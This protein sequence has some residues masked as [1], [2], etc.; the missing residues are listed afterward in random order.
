M[1]VP[2]FPHCLRL[3]SGDPTPAPRGIFRSSVVAFTIFF[4]LVLIYLGGLEKMAILTPHDDLYFL[5]RSESYDVNRS[6]LAFIKEYPYS[7]LILV[8]RTLTV[9]LILFELFLYAL[10]LVFL[11]RQLALLT[12]SFGLAWA[13]VLPLAF[14]TYLHPLLERVTY[15]NLQLIL[16]PMVLAGTFYL[17]RTRGALLSL[18]T[19][20]GLVSVQMATRPEGFIFLLPP[21]LAILWLTW[22]EQGGE[23]LVRALSYMGKKIGVLIPAVAILPLAFILF[24]GLFH[25]FWAQTIM[26]SGPTG[27]SL[28]LLMQVDPG[29]E[30]GGR[31]APFPMAAMEKA[32]AQSP[33]LARARPYFEQNT[34]F[35]GWSGNPSVYFLTEDGSISGGHFQWAWLDASN[36]V[37][38]SRPRD[39]LAYQ[40]EVAAELEAAFAAGD[41][42]KRRVLTTALGPNFSLF[43]GYYWSSVWYL[44]RHLTHWEAPISPRP[45]YAHPL[46]HLER[47][48]DRLALR[49]SALLR[50]R[51]WFKEGWMLGPDSE[52]PLE[53]SLTASAR[54]QGHRVET[55][56]RPDVVRMAGREESNLRAGFR[57]EAGPVEGEMEG[58]LVVRFAEESRKIPIAELRLARVNR[59][60][61]IDGVLVR[62][63]Q[64]RGGAPSLIAHR[65]FQG[66]IAWSGFMHYFFRTLLI[67]TPF[68]LGFLLWWAG[69]EESSR[70]VTLVGLHLMVYVLVIAGLFGGLLAA[71]E[72]FM[73][74]GDEP[75]YLAPAAFCLWLAATFTMARLGQILWLF[76]RCSPGV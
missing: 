11:W 1:L 22:E 42:P 43:S 19:V 28:R 4:L 34:A 74:P 26:K 14:F 24:N 54:A 8:A 70:S 46:S 7:F 6:H 76:R 3:P 57:F 59:T 72:A 27:D 64:D 37:V 48:Y 61:N 56:D 18:L 68:V 17:L 55:M 66:V 73:Y 71:I 49:R 40:A 2:S 25:G 53:M 13:S 65:H 52:V 60:T 35:H 67:A 15:D 21:L 58:A 20:G 38:G 69:R 33:A 62:V 31:Y 50:Y 75:R 44:A 12:R 63:D 45:T 9:P 16:T 23:K 10:A 32:F 29:E 36:S 41:L 30:D 39:I 51:E 47:E 5:Q